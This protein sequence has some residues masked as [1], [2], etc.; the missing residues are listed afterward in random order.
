MAKL[1]DVPA[2]AYVELPKQARLPVN[3]KEVRATGMW[4]ETIE[5]LPLEFRANLRVV[6]PGSDGA[7][8]FN[9]E[10]VCRGANGLGIELSKNADQLTKNVLAAWS[11]GQAAEIPTALPDRVERR[12][13]ERNP[14]A[15]DDITEDLPRMRERTAGAGVRPTIAP[16]PVARSPRPG[17]P[18]RHQL[19]GASVLVI[20]DDPGCAK[21]LQSG[22]GRLGGSVVIAKTGVAGLELARE[23]RLNA[24]LLDWMLPV[25]SG[26]RVLASLREIAPELPVAVVS[27]VVQSGAM[28]A[29]VRQLGADE[30]F[31]KPF[32]LRHISDWIV[33]SMQPR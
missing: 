28:R 11:K 20:E 29:R 1:I 7:L 31:A 25:M 22:I 9:F 23:H 16:A 13:V 26:E 6:F 27:G 14:H 18:L 30:V 3:V 10:V 5:P 17:I 32:E 19:D 24:V 12:I 8:G 2:T 15:S 33:R 21:F 4:L